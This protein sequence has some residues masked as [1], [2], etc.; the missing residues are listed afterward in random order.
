MFLGSLG[1]SLLR[2]L[3]P[4]KGINRARKGRG[5]NGAG[6]G[7]LRAGYGKK[8]IFNTASSFD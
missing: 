6:E 4:G 7:V 3:L 8:W 2:N 5:I 1:A